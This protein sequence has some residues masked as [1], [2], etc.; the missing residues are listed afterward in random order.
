MKGS[1][2]SRAVAMALPALA[3][4]AAAPA[5]A[6]HEHGQ[7]PAAAQAPQMTPEEQKMM[8][9]WQK[10]GTP[11]PQHQKLAEMAGTW[12]FESKSWMSPGKPP[13][14]STGTAERSM[15][16]GGR[17]LKEKVSSTMFG[18]PFEGIGMTGYDNTTGRYWSSWI[19]S[20]ST[21]MMMSTGT[22]SDDGKCEFTSTMKDPATGQDMTMRMTSEHTGDTEVMQMY[23]P[24]P[25]GKEYL[26]M[27][28]R[29]T[30]VKP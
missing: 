10:A 23:M 1:K 2:L 24:D 6:Q 5:V 26:G 12:T 4:L 16:L 3:L 29:Y 19:D 8:E 28:L 14:L 15:V 9:A 21:A 17:V 22:C 18:Q 11:G 20:M 7:D 13:E 30:R 27:E 25:Q